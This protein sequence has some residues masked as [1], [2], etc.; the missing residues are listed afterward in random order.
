MVYVADA[1]AAVPERVHSFDDRRTGLKGVIVIHSTRMGPA[2][3][4]CR[5]HAYPSDQDRSMDAV[6][7]AEGMSYKNALAGLPLGGGKSVLQMP[8]GP[9]DRAALFHAF[10]REVA[11]LRGDY[12]T[13]ED[14]GTTVADM[15][16]VRTAT[17]HVA[18]LPAIDTAP[19]G[20]PSPWTARAVFLSIELA[21]EQKLGRPV[22][23]AT[24]AVQGLGAV[25]FALCTLLD[26]AGARL[27]IAEPR[28]EIAKRAR[29]LFGAEQMSVGGIISAQADV[30]APC[31]FGAVLTAKSIR[32]LKAGIVCGA[33]NN[34]LASAADGD[35]LADRGVLY[36]PDYVVNAGGIINVAAEYLAWDAGV[37]RA[38]VEAIP[39]TL[40]AIF[41]LA[42]REGISTARAWPSAFQPSPPTSGLSHTTIAPG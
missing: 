4:G 6:R 7:L 38:R 20:D 32:K 23:G 37:A 40:R 25:G 10:G 12:F 21:L 39:Q 29:K 33:A 22:K 3:G 27:I 5:F 9:F 24:V 18:G 13:A 1:I 15:A 28:T 41:E 16:Q 34:Q 17:N 8:T 42:E 26:K 2:A 11:E 30:F 35:L 19:G 36:A 14:V 31:A